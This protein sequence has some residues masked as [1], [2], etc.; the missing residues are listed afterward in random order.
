M[1]AARIDKI[2][3]LLE[4]DYALSYLNSQ[5][6]LLP[7]TKIWVHFHRYIFQCSTKWDKSIYR[8]AGIA[9]VVKLLP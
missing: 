4:T 2:N 5:M 7:C 1:K 3:P 9:L 6:S 8:S